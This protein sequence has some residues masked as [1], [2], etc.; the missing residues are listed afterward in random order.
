MNSFVKIFLFLGTFLFALQ[1]FAAGSEVPKYYFDGFGTEPF[2]GISINGDEAE[3]S[4]AEFIHHAGVD[5][6]NID[7]SIHDYL[8]FTTLP[9]EIRFE[10]EYLSGKIIKK[11]CIDDSKGDTHEY[12]VIV[13]RDEMRVRGCA[14]KT[15][16]KDYI[17]VLGKDSLWYADIKGDH[18]YYS[19]P[20]MQK[21]GEMMYITQNFY[22]LK[23]VKRGN[24]I[25]FAGD[26]IR[27]KIEQK[28][29]MDDTKGDTHKYFVELVR[30]GNTHIGCADGDISLLPVKTVRPVG[31]D[32][33]RHGC[34]LGAG[35]VWSYVKQ[36]CIR[37]FEIDLEQEYYQR[38]LKLIDTISEMGQKKVYHSIQ[39]YKKILSN[40][41][42]LKQKE[43]N[44]KVIAR[45]D[46][47]LEKRSS[48][49]LE[50]FKLEVMQQD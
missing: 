14:D 13:E 16:K 21:P 10:G 22:A 29:C 19:D 18:L 6:G 46:A 47:I 5:S 32:R 20:S 1:S 25:E 17:H 34:M 42:A 3:Y 50:L 23:F 45:I 12:E 2:W 8:T 44:E 7:V 26:G 43:I 4:E 49:L 11:Q 38:Y 27:G 36:K 35:F 31:G 30:N 33:D 40:F 28:V 48:S 9:T 37:T 15:Q 24:I 39:K 41:S